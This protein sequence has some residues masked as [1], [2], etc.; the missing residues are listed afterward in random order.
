MEVVPK[1]SSRQ[2]A[3]IDASWTIDASDAIDSLLLLLLW[4]QDI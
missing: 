2:D 4:V 1:C 3:S